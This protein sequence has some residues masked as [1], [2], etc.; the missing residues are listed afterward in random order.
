MIFLHQKPVS[1]KRDK[2]SC[3][4]CDEKFNKST[5]K[6]VKCDQAACAYEA[7][8]T[9]HKRYVLDKSYQKPHCMSCKKEW[10]PEFQKA[11]FSKA[12]WGDDFREAREK[13][14][15]EEEKTY[16]PPL[17]V[18]ADRLLRIAKAKSVQDAIRIEISVNDKNEDQLVRDQRRIHRNLTEK[19]AA[20]IVQYHNAHHGPVDVSK[21]VCTVKCPMQDCRGYLSDKY[22]CGLCHVTICKD[23]NEVKDMADAHAC[24]KDKV[25]T[26]TE[27]RKT[28]KPCPKCGMA[29]SK[30]DGCDQMFCI[31]SGCH[32]AFSWTSG[33]IETGVIHNPHYFEALR[34]GNIRDPRHRQHQ[35]G[36]GPMPYYYDVQSKLSHA[37]IGRDGESK[38]RHHYQR[39]VHHRQVTLQ[40]FLDQTARQADRLKYLTGEMDEKKFKQKVYVANLADER[41]KEERQII[42]TFVSVGE[43]LFRQLE[44]HNAV[45][46]LGQL[47]TVTD[48]T[49]AAI[50]ALDLK[51]KY[52]G[53]VKSSEILVRK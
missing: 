44:F 16:L 21:K 42:E 12:F 23:C 30:I 4:V 39:F 6:P 17:Q 43:E 38:F 18:E 15:F 7:C 20:A 35:G 29:I 50:I 26:M 36:C 51:H 5:R 37:P 22:V 52:V 25:A 19:Y 46:T 53:C 8:A 14:L 10:T 9:C 28:S 47:E 24:D 3:E 13:V 27:I 41:K 11:S 45:D 2:M 32:T 40:R 33:L 1:R 31:A 34:V 48:I 49:H